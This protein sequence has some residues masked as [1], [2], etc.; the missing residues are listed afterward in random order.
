MY[1]GTSTY[2][3]AFIAINFLLPTTALHLSFIDDTLQCLVRAYAGFPHTSSYTMAMVALAQSCKYKLGRRES[4]GLACPAKT[5]A[6]EDERVHNANDG[7]SRLD[8][9]RLQIRL[10]HVK[11][12]EKYHPVTLNVA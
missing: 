7:G 2:M 1:A 10:D 5:D 6:S 8:G 4:F 11:H 9:E 3:N 12:H